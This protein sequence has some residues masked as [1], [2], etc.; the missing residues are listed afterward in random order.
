MRLPAHLTA[1]GKAMLAFHDEAF[2]RRLYPTGRLPARGRRGPVS[3]KGL[4]DE[5]AQVRA[6]GCSVDDEGVREGVFCF[7][8]PV[9]DPAGQPVAGVGV[10]THKATLDR[11][12]EQRHREVVTEC[13][14]RLTQRLG[15]RSP[16][17]PAPSPAATGAASRRK[18]RSPS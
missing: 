16:I 8:A 12:G 1:S 14:A 2:V 15:G 6:R 9:F 4:L 11:K 5:L 17:V 10:C 18:T 13:A 7:G 3:L